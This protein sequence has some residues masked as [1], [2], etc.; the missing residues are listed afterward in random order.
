[1]DS[2]SYVHG[3]TGREATRLSDQA[4]TLVS[5]LHEGTVYPPGAK[6]LEPGCGTGSQTV[7]LAS[8]SPDAFFTCTDI[9][10]DSLKEAREKA[11]RLGIQNATFRV[12]DIFNLP[13]EDESFDHIFV[14]FVLEHIKDPVRALFALKRVLKKGGS[15]TL[16]EGDHGS[17]YFYPQS[18][19]AQKA[20]GCQV[21]LQKSM[22]GNP[23]IGREVYPLLRQAGFSRIRVQPKIVYVEGRDPG[24]AEGFTRKTFT[25]MIEG[26]RDQAVSAGLIDPETFDKGIRA[27]HRTAEED[28]VFNYTFFKG[29]AYKEN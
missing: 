9:S 24:L 10:P 7:T 13:F 12:A 29:V 21:R 17:A 25:A 19:E 2:G 5:L 15:I 8:A 20:V 11:E 28:G 22:G 16:I 1:M 6:V 23:Q 18:E 27:L 14:C 26:V 4:N 3:Y